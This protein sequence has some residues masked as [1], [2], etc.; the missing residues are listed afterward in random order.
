MSDLLKNFISMVSDVYCHIQY[1]LSFGVT[2]FLA[3]SQSCIR[4]S[5]VMLYGNIYANLAGF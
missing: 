1:M 5:R 3:Q 4:L 2:L